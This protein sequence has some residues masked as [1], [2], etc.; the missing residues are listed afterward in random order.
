MTPF[1]TLMARP[2]ARRLPPRA[3]SGVSGRATSP[4]APVS[5]PTRA[6]AGRWYEI[7][8]SKATQESD[9]FAATLDYR[10]H[11]DGGLSLTHRCH[12]LSLTGVIEERRGRAQPSAEGQFRVAYDDALPFSRQP[13]HLLA[14][15]EDWAL[16]GD[17]GRGRVWLLAREAHPEPSVLEAAGLALTTLGLDPELERAVQP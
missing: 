14:V 1:L 11:P 16:V 10:V 2:L 8:R 17:P 6:L 4:A 13:H 12:R 3:P 15:A 9:R 5:S 7:A